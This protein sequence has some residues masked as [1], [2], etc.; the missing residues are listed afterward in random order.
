M[1][2]DELKYS[3][4]D[5]KGIGSVTAGILSKAG[6]I[7]VADLLRMLPRTYEDR[8]EQVP[9]SDF[10]S[11]KAVNTIVEVQAH[12]FIGFGRKKTLKVYIS[13]SS[14]TGVLICFGRNFLQNKLAVGKRFFL[15]GVFSHKYGEIQST[16]FEVEEYSPDPRH[17][18]IILPVYPLSGNIKQGTMRR[19]MNYVIS[20]YTASIE[21]QLPETINRKY[22]FPSRSQALKNIHFPESMEKLHASMQ[23]LK[24]EELFYLQLII[25]RR[26]LKYK[27]KTR[28]TRKLPFSLKNKLVQSLPFSLT[29]DQKTVLGEI[30]KDMESEAPMYRL[31][32]GDV[33]CGKTLVAFIAALGIIEGGGQTAFMA[34]TELLARQHGENAG[35]LLASLGVRIAYLSGSIPAKQRRLLLKALKEGSIDLLIGTHALFTRDV[36]FKNLQFVIVDEQHK[37]GVLQRLALL[38]KG[39]TPDLLLMTATPIPRTLTMTV[40]ADLDISVIKTMPEGR[41]AVITHL[42][43]M[44]NRRKVFEAVRSELKKGHQAY[45]VYPRIGQTEKEEP[46]Q[47]HDA[48]TMFSYLKKKVYP[49]FRLGLVHSKVPEDRKETVMEGFISGTIDILVAT[50]VV[51]V[52]VDVKNATCMVIEHAERFGLS[53]LHQLRGRVG[54]GEAQSY[55]FLIYSDLLGDEGKERLRVMMEHRDGFS[56]SEEDLRIR[57]PGELAGRQQSG[58]LKLTFADIL[59]DTRIRN[60]ARQDAAA[61]LNTDPGFIESSHRMIREVFE[62]C[63]P[64]E[65]NLLSSG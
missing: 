12:D 8:K 25:A 27:R 57:G 40:F 33:G 15:Y 3:I 59:R 24:Y 10:A 65:D 11:G 34:P 42:S 30:Q 60:T 45:F 19:I 17:F 20:T 41:K 2:A 55:A 54:R 48:E 39:Q 1:Y 14:A 28:S 52:G 4:K 32:Q 29:P 43:K 49:E 63:P 13:D 61:I 35:R 23:L 46:A 56:L 47:L 18:N 31:L 9:L 53:G 7:T 64:F 38:D 58:F 37:F 44:D 5:I 62:R 22:S 16:Q 36:T 51:E 6:I 21:N 26:A 50:S